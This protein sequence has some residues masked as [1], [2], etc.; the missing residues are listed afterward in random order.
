MKCAD[1]IFNMSAFLI[2]INCN[3][4]C[5]AQKRSALIRWLS[6]MSPTFVCI[7][8]THSISDEEIESWFSSF[9]SVLAC[10]H[11]SRKR[12]G[13]AVLCC[14]PSVRSLSSSKDGDGRFALVEVLYRNSKIHI[15]SIYAPNA[16]PERSH[17][18]DSIA[19][20]FDPLACNLIAGDFNTVFDPSID[21]RGGNPERG[22]DSPD[23]LRDLLRT[24][25]T[26]DVWRAKH[27]SVKSFS[28]Q[29]WNGTIASRIDYI[30]CPL[31]WSP[32]VKSC[33]F[34]PCPYSDHCAVSLSMH[35]I[36][37]SVSIGPGYWK[38]NC[39]ILEEP[40]LIDS[41][42]KFWSRWRLEKSRFVSPLS[43]WDVGKAHVKLICLDFSRAKARRR[44]SLQQRLA[45]DI[46]TL[47]S[48]LDEGHLSF[49]PHYNE[50]LA[51][52]RELDSIAVRGARV[53]ARIKWAE[54]G[55][56]SS[57]YFCRLERDRAANRV[58]SSVESSNGLTSSSLETLSAFREFYSSL[59]TSDGSEPSVRSLLLNHLNLCL[60]SEEAASCEGSLTLDECSKALKGMSNGRSPGLD[61]LP[62]EFY[63]TFWELLGQDLVDVLNYAHYSGSM[64]SSQRRGLITLLH[65]KGERTDRSN[66]RPIS[67]LSVD[68]KIASRAIALRLLR[69]IGSVTSIDQ[70]CGVPSRF[71]GDNTALLR[72]LCH[73][74]EVTD[75]QAAV[76]FL[77][78][79]KAF[80]RVEWPFLMAVLKKMGFGDSFRRWVETFYSNPVS[81]VI[82][83]QFISSSFPLSRGVRQGCPLSPLLY[84]LCAEVLASK[85]RASPA[86]QGVRLPQSACSSRVSQYADDTCIII[87][88]LSSLEA[89]FRYFRLYGR[90]SGAK[91]NLDKCSGLWLGRWRGRSDSPGGL[92]W[93]SSSVKSL[94]IFIGND[95]LSHDNFDPRILKL[96]NKLRSWSRRKLSLSGKSF[97]VSS[98]ALSGLYY[99]ITSCPV[100]DW[101]MKKVSSL[102]WPFLWDNKKDMVSRKTC[103]LP[104]SQ[105]GLGFPDF[106]KRITAFHGQWIMRFL[107]DSPAKWK[108]FLSHWLTRCLPPGVG[109]VAL[110]DLSGLDLSFFPAFYESAL[111]AWKL[112]GGAGCPYTVYNSNTP[113]SSMRV[114]DSYAFLLTETGHTPHCVVKWTPQF[115]SLYW[116]STWK[117]LSFSTFNRA[118]IDLSWKVAHGVPFTLD[119]L[120]SFGFTNLK[121]CFCGSPSESLEHLF[122]SC[123]LAQSLLGWVSVL[124]YSAEPRCPSLLPRHML[125]GF[126]SSE[127]SVIPKVFVLILVLLKW[128]IWLN[129]NDF[130]FCDKRPC[131]ANCLASLR[132]NLRFCVGCHFRRLSS[133]TE[134]IKDWCA[135]GN[136]A[137]I[138]NGDL[139]FKL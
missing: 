63:V 78:Q 33:T 107:S 101:V 129:R 1:F 110:R 34:I 55:E 45:R 126:D 18:L 16:D 72:D 138:R 119:R 88:S 69:V 127:L 124:F 10:S 112:L 8:E 133:E 26:I 137:C 128:I 105:G 116:E 39:S 125:F 121:N 43:W 60:S 106:P 30:F 40:A 46:E 86:I 31:D 35:S 117:Q 82:V 84:V 108:F 81:C 134:F 38:L 73:Y 139:Y 13:V 14:D 42:T 32:S 11:G 5:D 93:S 53:R 6:H 62:K 80:D 28:W 102:I 47:K 122:F 49:L 2:S 91:L 66:W 85:I 100:P 51:C 67:L 120:R 19:A 99:T 94:G 115:G 131:V 89:L 71:I 61:G 68:Y 20:S 97:V 58:I 92:K 25:S 52:Q 76:L 41:V 9:G 130:H 22:A 113:V 90:A 77:D 103:V 123:P 21:R 56:T 118:A 4:L 132:A 3:G 48:R 109:N 50:V 111:N 114:K 7:Q 57:S 96:S 29:K 65:K 79:Q 36:P 136:I 75:S 135:N 12:A 27:P 54:E 70:T 104:K 23:R 74:C 59:F 95:D 83:N 44:K 17:F 87:R 24:S 64:S 15:A 37:H 98:L